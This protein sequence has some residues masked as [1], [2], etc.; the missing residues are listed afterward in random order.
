MPRLLLILL[1]IPLL[2]FC[3]QSCQQKQ[4]NN[5]YA[6][7]SNDPQLNKELGD[8]FMAKNKLRAGVVTMPSGLQYFVVRNGVGEPPR[9]RDLVTVFYKGQFLNGKVFD[10]QHFQQKPVTVGLTS[11]IPGW[12]L[13]LMQMQPGSVWVIYV[14]P[15]L[16]YGVRGIPG[17]IPGNQTLVYTIN[18]I[19][20]QKR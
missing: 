15:A 11:V 9:I 4:R 2:C 18:L 16:G 1:A 5:Q 3:L 10:E 7:V 19:N 8:L 14:P 20:Y 13:A 17:Y 6:L 12:Q